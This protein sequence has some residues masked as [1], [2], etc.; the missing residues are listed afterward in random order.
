MTVST[1]S[2]RLLRLWTR[3]EAHGL[4]TVAT[5]LMAVAMGVMVVEAVSRYGWGVSHWWAEELVRYLVV[6]SMLLSI[7]VA[8]RRGHFIRMDLLI[9]ALP[10]R[11]QLAL[12]WVTV[13]VGVAFCG[14]L[15]YASVIEVRHLYRI[16]M[17]TESNLDLPLWVV[18]LVLPVGAV[19]YGLYFIGCGARLARGE[20]PFRAARRDGADPDPESEPATARAPT[21]APVTAADAVPDSRPRPV[22][23]TRPDPGLDPGLDPAVADG[24][25]R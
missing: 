6:W 8:S 9:T 5:V 1:R 14:V 2:G 20:D 16:G 12:G 4:L 13:V 19:L 3:V 18:R 17:Y 10:R 23:E 15:L 21:V 24:G 22:I 25:V 7:G 11:A